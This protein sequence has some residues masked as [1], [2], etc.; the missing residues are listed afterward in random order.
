[1]RQATQLHYISQTYI[2]IIILCQGNIICSVTVLHRLS[3]CR[4]PSAI[5]C[6]SL[7]NSSTSWR[8]WAT[9]WLSL[10]SRSSCC[11]HA[12]SDWPG[13][14]CKFS[15][16]CTRHHMHTQIEPI[17]LCMYIFTQIHS[18]IMQYRYTVYVAVV[19][20]ICYISRSELCDCLLS[21]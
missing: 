9:M 6:T 4:A 21:A 14:S 11:C 17:A 20:Q 15:F 16:R 12:P 13:V 3:Q 5:T 18:S 1:M 19:L 10:E 8:H 7:L 2:D